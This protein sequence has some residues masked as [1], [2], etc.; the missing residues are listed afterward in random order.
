MIWKG[1]TKMGIGR[2]EN[3][4]GKVYVVINYSPGGKPNGHFSANVFPPGTKNVIAKI[5]SEVGSKLD[6]FT[7]ECVDAHNYYRKKHGVQP[8]VLDSQA[9]IIIKTTFKLSPYILNRKL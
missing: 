2:A 9:K 7:Q 6:K 5:K 4:S 8:L 3:V 1:S